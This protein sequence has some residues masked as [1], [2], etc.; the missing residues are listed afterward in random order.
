MSQVEVGIYSI[1]PLLPLAYYAILG[2]LL[3]IKQWLHIFEYRN[4]DDPF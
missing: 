2:I 1:T 4:G 3:C